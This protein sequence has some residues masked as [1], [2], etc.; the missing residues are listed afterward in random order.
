MP[1]DH[2]LGQNFQLEVMEHSAVLVSSQGPLLQTEPPR[3]AHMLWYAQNTRALL[4]GFK[5]KHILR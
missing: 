1:P 3:A 2:E 4:T 5:I